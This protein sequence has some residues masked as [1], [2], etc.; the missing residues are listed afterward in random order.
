MEHGP[1]PIA[2]ARKVMTHGTGVQTGIDPAEQN[3]KIRGDEIRNFP[4]PCSAYFF[5][6]GPGERCHE[7]RA[8]FRNPGA[9][10]CW[11]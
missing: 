11:R 5:T 10:L 6:R 2:R 9:I 7:K 8:A 1:E 4:P 3:E